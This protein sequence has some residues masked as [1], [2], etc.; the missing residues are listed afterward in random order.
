MGFFG[1]LNKKT[2]FI[3]AV[4]YYANK[5]W[6]NFYFLYKKI[7][8]TKSRTLKKCIWQKYYDPSIYKIVEV[9]FK[10]IK[11]VLVKKILNKQ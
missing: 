1:L 5:Y 6:K 2:I 7:Y 3:D 9:S 4:F 10:D 11:N 8:N